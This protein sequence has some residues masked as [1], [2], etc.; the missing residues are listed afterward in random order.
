MAIKREART[1]IL[2]GGKQYGTNKSIRA[3]RRAVSSNSI[4]FR[5]E[6]LSAPARLDTIAGA[7]YQDGR[8]WWVIAAAS[9]IGWSLQ[10]DAGTRLVIPIDLEEI[11]ELIG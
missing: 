11:A 3:I 10:A 6:S 5:V 9:N 4:S 1:P 7:E 8:M 2:N